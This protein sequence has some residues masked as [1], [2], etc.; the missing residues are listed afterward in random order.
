MK[1]YSLLMIPLLI[2]PAFAADEHYEKTESIAMT[3]SLLMRLSKVGPIGYV[4]DNLETYYGT[5]AATIL[6]DDFKFGW[7][8]QHDEF[9]L[10]RSTTSKFKG[11]A[12]QPGEP[13]RIQS[14]WTSS[15]GI[16]NPTFH[17][18]NFEDSDLKSKFNDKEKVTEIWDKYTRCKETGFGSHTKRV[19][20]TIIPSHAEFVR[21]YKEAQ[22][23][24]QT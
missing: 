5:I 16:P 4:D 13:V 11:S 6:K 17:Q 12:H 9:Q 1:I 10:E 24:K 21:L 2:S 3:L 15:N 7:T 23:K 18:K 20:A 22:T 8:A 19:C 14:I